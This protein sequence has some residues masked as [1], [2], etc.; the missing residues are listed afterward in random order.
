MAF[1]LSGSQVISLE[2]VTF[3]NK[4]SPAHIPEP[5]RAYESG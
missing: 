4:K 1:Q 3:N 2:A 5:G